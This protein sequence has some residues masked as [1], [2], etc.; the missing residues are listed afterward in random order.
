MGLQEHSENKY[1]RLIVGGIVGAAAAYALY[2]L[3]TCLSEC[4]VYQTEDDYFGS[5]DREVRT[6]CVF[7]ILR[8]RI[9]FQVGISGFVPQN[10]MFLL[11]THSVCYKLN[12]Y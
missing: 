6:I 10:P 8:G 11:P 1:V 3:F 5:V 9:C 2:K 4:D 7:L 12:L